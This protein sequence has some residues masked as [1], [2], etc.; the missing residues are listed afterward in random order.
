MREYL[1]NSSLQNVSLNK[2]KLE[3]YFSDTC[4]LSVSVEALGELRKVLLL[5]LGCAVQCERKEQFIENIKTL[6]IDVQ[7]A[8]VEH[9][10]E[11][12][13]IFALQG[14]APHPGL[15]TRPDYPAASL[16]QTGP[17][18]V[19]LLSRGQHGNLA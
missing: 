4:H 14:A 1:Y 11:V 9:I 19:I 3:E 18:V 13:T 12:S 15:A 8:M 16:V 17:V 2:G 6:D 7:H 5:L 10:K